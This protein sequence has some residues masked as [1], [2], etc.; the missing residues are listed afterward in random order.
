M[1]R[2]ADPT[3]VPSIP[4][5]IPR[6]ARRGLAQDRAAAKRK[7]V[8]SVGKSRR[9][10]I[11][12]RSLAKEARLL[13]SLLQKLADLERHAHRARDLELAGHVGEGRVEIAL[14]QLLQILQA[15]R[16]RGVAL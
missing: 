10:G 14:D 3:A 1:R 15:E 8:A 7:S 2:R 9:H 16:E 12:T 5:A 4:R 11:V 6:K 13:R